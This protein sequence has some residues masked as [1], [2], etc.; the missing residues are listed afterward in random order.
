[1]IVDD[2]SRFSRL[3]FLSHKDETFEAF[4][5]LYRKVQNENDLKIASVRSDHGEFENDLFKI[6]FDENG[7]SCNFSCPRTPQ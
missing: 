4:K 2:V 3:L 6:F 5:K 1:M 7:F